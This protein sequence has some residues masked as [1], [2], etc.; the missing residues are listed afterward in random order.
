MSKVKIFVLK[1]MHDKQLAAKY[2]TENKV[3]I[4]NIRKHLFRK[5]FTLKIKGGA[6]GR[7][8]GEVF[9]TKKYDCEFAFNSMLKNGFCGSSLS[10]R[11]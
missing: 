4:E 3:Y 5:P 9:K 7:V 8:L 1:T 2:G 6:L 11:T 10:R